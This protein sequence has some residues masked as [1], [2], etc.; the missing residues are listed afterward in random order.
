VS[1]VGTDAS[2]R[3]VSIDISMQ[4]RIIPRRPRDG[5]STMRVGARR[6]DHSP[7]AELV[8]EMIRHGVAIGAV[9]YDD[10]ESVQRAD[11]RG[12]SSSIVK[13]VPASRE[14]A[15]RLDGVGRRI[16]DMQQRDPDARSCCRDSGASCLC[17]ARENPPAPSSVT[18]ACA[19]RRHI[20]PASVRCIASTS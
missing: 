8:G 19:P 11:A 7:H 4:P 3:P 2:A 6:F 18:A 12:E 5:R 1:N 13:R 15:G 10:V 9:R 14:Y 16:S 20:G 17:R